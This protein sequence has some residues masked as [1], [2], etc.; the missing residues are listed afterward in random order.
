MAIGERGVE[1]GGQRPQIGRDFG[2]VFDAQLARCREPGGQGFGQ[3]L[4]GVGAVVHVLLGHRDRRGPVADRHD[5]GETGEPRDG[6]E[7]R[8][9][10]QERGHLEI[11]VEPG[12]E[13]AVCLEDQ[14]LGE[15]HGGVR[16]VRAE[17]PFRACGDL[18]CPARH[19]FWQRGGGAAD[20][21]G[22]GWGVRVG[23]HREG[24]D[25]PP[26]PHRD[27]ECPPHSIAG[28]GLTHRLPRE[29]E[30]VVLARAVV[31]GQR[32]HGEHVR[33]RF[34][35]DE[36]LVEG[37][38][39]DRA[40][41]RAEPASLRDRLEIETPDRGLDLCARA[42]TAAAVTATR[43]MRSAARF[44]PDVALT[45]FDIAFRRLASDLSA[46]S[47]SMASVSSSSRKP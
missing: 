13:A 21:D 14:A 40:A 1:A 17:I 41:L 29:R 23:I 28:H 38:D 3:P 18:R 37:R 45:R 26:L 2:R 7:G 35:E 31:E 43:S 42:Q 44:V 25:D 27:P 9:L 12:L 8:L 22:R 32:D 30:R 4:E 39:V 10:G 11:R 15:H 33:R 6:R 36:R 20:E 16:L 46:T 34:V 5:L 47:S 24:G 19:E